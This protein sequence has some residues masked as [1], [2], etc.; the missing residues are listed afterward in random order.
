MVLEME[1]KKK[2]NIISEETLPNCPKR[3]NGNTSLIFVNESKD[4]M[5][6]SKSGNNT[7]LKSDKGRQEFRIIF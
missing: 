5:R 6:L 7:S 4:S 2:R 1:N 3:L